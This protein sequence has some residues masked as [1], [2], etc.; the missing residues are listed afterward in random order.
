MQREPPDVLR[1]LSDRLQN[2]ATLGLHARL[3]EICPERLRVNVVGGCGTGKKAHFARQQSKIRALL[4]P[5]SR[6]ERNFF[7]VSH[8]WPNR[9][10]RREKI[11]GP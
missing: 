9:P 8:I 1:T 2:E 5:A 10:G 7:Q 11:A 6:W 3:G 4:Q